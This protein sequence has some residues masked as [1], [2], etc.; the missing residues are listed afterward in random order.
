M[1]VV[2]LVD[3]PPGNVGEDF[4]FELSLYND[5]DQMVITPGLM[6]GSVDAVRFSQNLTVEQPVPV[7]DGLRFPKDAIWSRRTV[8]DVSE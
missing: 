6:A 3:V 4:A 8:V 5:A 1:T 7:G 2:V